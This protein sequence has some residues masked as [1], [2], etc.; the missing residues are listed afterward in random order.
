MIIAI[1]EYSWSAIKL[2]REAVLLSLL[3][4][5]HSYLMSKHLFAPTCVNHRLA[6]LFKMSVLALAM[7]TTPSYAQDFIGYI[8]NTVNSED[9]ALIPGTPW[10]VAS[11]DKTPGKPK[12]GN[13]YAIDSRTNIAHSVDAKIAPHSTAGE[14]S[15]RPVDLHHLAMSGLGMR[16]LADGTHQL[17]AVNRGERMSIEFFDIDLSAVTPAF[18]WAGCLIMPDKAFPNAVVPIQDGGL[19]VTISFE[20]DNTHLIQQLEG[21]Q[22]TGYLLEWRPSRGFQ[23]VPGSELPLDNGVKIDPSG[24][25]YYLA[26]WGSETLLRLPTSKGLGSALRV[27]LGLK[28]DNLSWSDTGTLIVAGQTQSATT[29]FQCVASDSD[30]CRTPFKVIEIDPETLTTVRTL[31][32]GQKMDTYSAAT[33]G[34]QVGKELWVS[35]FRNNKIARYTLNAVATRPAH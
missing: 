16:T 25:Y 4:N 11:S 27:N 19:A 8:K 28:P 12:P 14:P 2:D 23:R 3:D 32:D 1:Y 21:K 22:N 20:T 29:I 35:A 26:G 13:L 7:T 5:W 31:V 33:T 17:M 30:I 18:T 10:V 6:W 24:D 9:L 15:C 34:L